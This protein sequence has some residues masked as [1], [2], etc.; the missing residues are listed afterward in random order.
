MQIIEEYISLHYII[1]RGFTQ[2][3]T[4]KN[5]THTHIY[6]YKINV[7]ISYKKNYNVLLSMYF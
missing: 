4:Y 7:A 1:F 2:F 6:T 5:N 3:I